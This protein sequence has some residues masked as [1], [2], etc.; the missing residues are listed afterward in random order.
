MLHVIA[1]VLVAMF[2]IFDIGRVFDALVR[3]RPSVNKR[4]VQVRLEKYPSTVAVSLPVQWRHACTNTVVG[5]NDPAHTYTAFRNNSAE[6]IAAAIANVRSL[7]EKRRC[8][9]S[10]HKAIVNHTEVNI[11]AAGYKKSKSTHEGLLPNHDT[12]FQSG[13]APKMVPTKATSAARLT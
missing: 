3:W 7:P 9:R 2:S 6:H 4:Y 1:A 8:P 12:D 13:S 11:S 5:L 10:R